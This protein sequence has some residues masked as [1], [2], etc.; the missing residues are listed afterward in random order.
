MQKKK[1]A[2]DCHECMQFKLS[3][4][5]EFSYCLEKSTIFLSVTLFI[6]II[7]FHSNMLF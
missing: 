3:T 1:S 7:N 2:I 4:I 5:P 6:I